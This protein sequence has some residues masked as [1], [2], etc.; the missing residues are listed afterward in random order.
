MIRRGRRVELE[1][2]LVAVVA[3]GDEQRARGER[4][5]LEVG[6]PPEPR[7]VDFELGRFGRQLDV[8][9]PV[10]EQEDRLG[11]DSGGLEQP[12]PPLPDLRM[13]V[14]VRQHAAGLVRLR[15]ERDDDATPVAP[16]AVRP[17]VVLHEQPRR[18]HV[19]AL[20]DPARQPLPVQAPR[21]VLRLGEGQV[22]DVVRA[23]REE[24]LA[25]VGSDRVV[26]RRHEVRDRAGRAGV[27]DGAK[28]LQVG[29][30][31]RAYQR[32]LAATVAAG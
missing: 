12:L 27:A 11:L 8:E 15:G 26:G 22:E 24:S 30:R 4:R 7:A 3:V 14:L 23:Q 20:E 2:A 17:D 25:L 9:I 5:E 10:D 1:R 18:G 16:D 19:L 6:D 32:P 29:H 31:G 13:R 21:L 28:R